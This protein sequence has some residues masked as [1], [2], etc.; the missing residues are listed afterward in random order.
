MYPVHPVR[1]MLHGDGRGYNPREVYVTPLG[2]YELITGT[3]RDDGVGSTDRPPRP[4]RIALHSW[5]SGVAFAE[6]S[7]FLCSPVQRTRDHNQSNLSAYPPERR[8]ISS[9]HQ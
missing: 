3:F 2:I 6:Y 7:N 9:L 1:N 4:F 8:R 5:I